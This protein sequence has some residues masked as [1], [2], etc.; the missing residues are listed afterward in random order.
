MPIYSVNQ[1]KGRGPLWPHWVIAAALGFVLSF[2]ITDQAAPPAGA[3]T[4]ASTCQV[5]AR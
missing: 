4:T 3:A 2:A 5:A 1:V